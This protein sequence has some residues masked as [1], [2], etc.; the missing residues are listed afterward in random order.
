MGT[1]T[2]RQQ[3]VERG[4]ASSAHRVTLRLEHSKSS[5][6]NILSKCPAGAKAT[7]TVVNTDKT[8]ISKASYIAFMIV[9]KHEFETDL[10]SRGCSVDR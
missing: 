5:A 10:L 1:E 6:M 7:L 2:W 8:V 9:Y 4:S 3:P